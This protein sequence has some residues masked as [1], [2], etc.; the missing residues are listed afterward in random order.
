MKYTE[1]PKTKDIKI[2][3]GK[4]EETFRKQRSEN[5]CLSFN[6][7]RMRQVQPMNQ[8]EEIKSKS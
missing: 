5:E 6:Q 3:N 2:K 4:V 1:C 8:E 7:E